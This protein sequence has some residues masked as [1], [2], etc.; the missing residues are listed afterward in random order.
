MQQQPWQC[1]QQAKASW[2]K[3]VTA[4][5]GRQCAA[6]LN[7]EKI[8]API[9]RKNSWKIAQKAR[10]SFKKKNNYDLFHGKWSFGH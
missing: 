8:A 7:P 2:R 10:M 4:A 6:K 5:R 9:W 3:Q 1:Q